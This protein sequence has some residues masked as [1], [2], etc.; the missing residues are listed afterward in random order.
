MKILTWCRLLNKRFLKKPAFLALLALIPVLAVAL[1]LLTGEGGTI[2]TVALCPA[3]EISE[4]VAAALME[5]DG[6][7]HYVPAESGEAARAMVADGEADAAWIFSERSDALIRRYAL[8]DSV[9]APVVTVVEREDNVF[10]RL[11]REKLYAALFPSVSRA[12]WEAFLA[13]ESGVDELSEESLSVYEQW[14][15]IDDAPIRF[16]YM[17]GT[18][19]EVGDDYLRSPTR[20]L[21]AIL[22]ILGALAAAM[23]Y[24]RDKRDGT[25]AWVSGKALFPLSAAYLLLPMLDMAAMAYLALYLTGLGG[26]FG[27]EALLL[28]LLLVSGA[29]FAMLIASLCGS[30]A[31]IGVAALVLTVCM[32]ALCPVFLNVRALRGASMLLP[33]YYYLHAVHNRDFALYLAAYAAVVWLLDFGLFQLQK[34][35]GAG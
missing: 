30:E 16:S 24:V 12:A 18:V 32:L 22:L 25:L 15:E 4:E 19:A 5:E 10:L 34:R 13:R 35:K 8:G 28:A 21:L 14:I 17:D 9:R 20:G 3:D 1:M 11:A 2:L 29:G 31:R 27:Y 23:V 26:G 7:L 6:V 33:P